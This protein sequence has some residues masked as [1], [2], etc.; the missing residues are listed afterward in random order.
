MWSK[1]IQRVSGVPGDYTYKGIPIYCASGV[2]EKVFDLIKARYPDKGRSILILGAGSGSFDERLMDSGYTNITAVE[3]NKEVYKS[4]GKILGLDLN[5]DFHNDIPDTFDCIVAIEIIE[6]LEN[7]FH[8]IR[9]IESLLKKGGVVF[10]TTPNVE[11]S[12]SRVKFWLVG[13]F[14][15]FTKNSIMETGHINPLFRHIFFYYVNNHTSLRLVALHFNKSVWDIWGGSYAGVKAKIMLLFA[16][17]LSLVTVHKDRR[18][19]QIFE[20]Q[21]TA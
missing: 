3:F 17:L 15:C 16:G 10:I 5:Q 7:H 18:E 4:R 21:K 9:N 14:P 2:H 12:L 1:N 20:M 8:F 19:I 6:H 13:D 11:S